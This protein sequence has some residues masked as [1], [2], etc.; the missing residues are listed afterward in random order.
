MSPTPFTIGPRFDQH[1]HRP[2]FGE[3]WTEH[4]RVLGNRVFYFQRHTTAEGWS[5]TRALERIPAE[6][7]SVPGLPGGAPG[8]GPS[9]RVIHEWSLVP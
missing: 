1:R 5:T 7:V 8:L 4:M 6:F 3:Q 2:D 9:W